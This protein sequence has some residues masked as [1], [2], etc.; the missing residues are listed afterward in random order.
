MIEDY[1][2]AY[3]LG[4]ALLRYF[5][6]S[7]ADPDGQHGEDRRHETHLIPLTLQ[8]ASGKRDRA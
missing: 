4:Y 7:G 6:A 1:A 8:V 3:G 2:A 5:N